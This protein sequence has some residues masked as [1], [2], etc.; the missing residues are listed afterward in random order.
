MTG[1]YFTGTGNTR[2]CVETFLQE[3]GAEERAFS[4]E[5]KDA[6]LEI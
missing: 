4:I 1:M 3:Y 6:V 2:Y 5:D